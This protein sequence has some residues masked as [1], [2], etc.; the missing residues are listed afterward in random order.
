MATSR[1]VERVAELI[2][3]EISQ[4]LLSGIKDDRVGQGL[5]SV[6]AV[7]V[8]GDLQHAQVYVSI[9]GSPEVRAQTMAGL[10]SATG[11]VR[12]VL[13][14]RMRLRHTPEVVFR[15]DTSLERGSRVIALLNQIRQNHP[16]EEG[17]SN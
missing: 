4:L 13:G 15:E 6:T 11:Y 14:Q 1:R 12:A 2:K 9:Y 8:S 5:V 7:E 3:R 10:A 17:E 16:A